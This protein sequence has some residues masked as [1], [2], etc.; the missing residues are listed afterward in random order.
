MPAE[1][2]SLGQLRQERLDAAN[3][4]IQV[5][6]RCGRRFFR[7]KGAGHDAYLSMN[8]RGTIVWLHDDYTSARV[9]VAKEGEWDGFSHGG[10]LKSLVGS[11]GRFVLDDSKM[12]YG[13]FQPKM[14]N[15]FENPWGYGDDILIVRDEG[16]RLGLIRKPAEAQEAA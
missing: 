4:F 11:I 5:I 2:K 8:A 14:D 9:N 13:Y 10:T 7:N 12:R 16:V 3:A 15:G 1:K 6:A